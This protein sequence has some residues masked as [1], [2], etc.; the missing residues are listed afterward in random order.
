MHYKLH[1]KKYT[2]LHIM[3]S[4]KAF[5]HLFNIKSAFAYTYLNFV[6]P[7]YYY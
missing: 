5:K 2:V 6:N 3:T 7:K 4:E 1:N